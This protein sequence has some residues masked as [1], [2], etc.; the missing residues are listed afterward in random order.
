MKRIIGLTAALAMLLTAAPVAAQVYGNPVYVPVGV[1][2]GINIA[3]DVAKGTNDASWKTMYYG[4]RASVGFGSFYASAAVGSVKPDSALSDG[5]GS[6]TGFGGT[7]G[8]HILALPMTPIK[9]SAQAGA[10][11]I[12]EGDYKQMDFPIAVALGVSLPGPLGIT[13]WVAP[14]LHIRSADD[15][16]NSETD[17]WF[18]A[19]GGINV[20]IGM[21]GI[22]LAADYLNVPVP[23]GAGGT[24]SDYSPWIFGGGLNIGIKVPGL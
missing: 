13:P 19:S 24:S 2:T 4:A 12:K 16:V 23:E 22:H 8:Y 15:G 17:T 10:G 21:I 9:V 3:G 20:S 11:Y 14:R 18:G 6:Q 1:G 7:L 5:A